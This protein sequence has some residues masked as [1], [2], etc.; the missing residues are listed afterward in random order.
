MLIRKKSTK[1]RLQKGEK[2]NKN[3]SETDNCETKYHCHT[4]KQPT[5]KLFTTKKKIKNFSLH[6]LC[7][8]KVG[9]GSDME[10]EK[11]TFFI[12]HISRLALPL[13]RL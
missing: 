11:K 2:H 1:N 8:T 13:L 5:R 3:I 4:K 9:G 7:F 10:N 6:Y 12:F